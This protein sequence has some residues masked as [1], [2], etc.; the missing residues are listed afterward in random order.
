MLLT[1]TSDIGEC[2]LQDV[3]LLALKA[4]QI[5]PIIEQLP[6]LLGPD[7]VVVTLHCKTVF[8]GGTFKQRR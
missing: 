7:T 4:H 5:A 2:G 1:A 6:S 8:P 3:V